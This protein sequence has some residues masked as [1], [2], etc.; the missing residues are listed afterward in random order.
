MAML[1]CQEANGFFVNAPPGMRAHHQGFDCPLCSS[2]RV[3]ATL[4]LKLMEYTIT[5]VR[6][7]KST[8]P[9]PNIN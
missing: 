9:V 5:Q 1:E 2:F 8:C 4:D 3:R 6:F 7:S